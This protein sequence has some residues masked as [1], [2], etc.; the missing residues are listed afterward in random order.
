MSALVTASKL[1]KDAEAGGYALGA[2][3][4]VNLE[5]LAFNSIPLRKSWEA[6]LTA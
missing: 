1:Y 5:V 4:T 2:F 6:L 3:N